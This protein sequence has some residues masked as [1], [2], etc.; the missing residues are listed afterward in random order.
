MRSPDWR[1]LLLAAAGLCLPVALSSPA[2]ASAAQ[3]WQLLPNAQLASTTNEAW[4][5]RLEDG[6]LSV[7]AY[8]HRGRTRP[9][10]GAAHSDD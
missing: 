1:L 2:V 5:L 6:R 4:P 7:S 3:G 9:E 8:R 10:G